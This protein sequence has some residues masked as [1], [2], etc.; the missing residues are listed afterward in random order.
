MPLSVLL[1]QPLSSPLLTGAIGASLVEPIWLVRN[2]VTDNESGVSGFDHLG[3]LLGVPIADELVILQA[4]A[5]PGRCLCWLDHCPRPTAGRYERIYLCRQ[6][7]PLPLPLAL[8]RRGAEQGGGVAGVGGVPRTPV[9]PVA[10]G[11]RRLAA[12]ARHAP[13]RSA[14]AGWRGSWR[15]PP[16]RSNIMAF[17]I[18]LD[19]PR[20]RQPLEFL[21]GVAAFA[22][23]PTGDVALDRTPVRHHRAELVFLALSILLPASTC[24]DIEPLVGLLL[25]LE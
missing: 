25:R 3:W 12:G 22:L 6:Y 20:V 14:P 4:T 2:G 13:A 7:R 17:I 19:M 23:G 10:P 18:A 9:R 15:L 5:L 1:A 11:R 21:P 24:C 8:E 16:C